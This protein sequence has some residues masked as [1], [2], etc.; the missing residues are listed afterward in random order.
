MIH[1]GKSYIQRV[2]GQSRLCADITIGNHRNTLWFSVDNSQEQYLCLGRADAFVMAFLAAAMRGDHELVCEDPMS[3]RLH[4]QLNCDLIPA[5]SSAIDRYHPIHITAPLTAEPYPNAGA[6]GTAFSGGVDSLYTI[7]TH[8][9]DCGYPISHIVVYNSS[10]FDQFGDKRQKMFLANCRQVVRF[11]GTYGLQAVIVDTNFYNV[12]GIESRS[13]VF[14]FRNVAC[15]LAL[16]GLLSCYLLSSAFSLSTF[17]LNCDRLDEQHTCARYDWLIVISSFT[18]SLS[19]Y[20]SG[21][22]IK[23]WQKIQKLAD[24]QPSWQWLHPCWFNAADKTNC[25]CCGKCICDLVTLYAL[26]TDTLNRYSKVFNIPDF[27]HHLPERVAYVILNA[28]SNIRAKEAYHLLKNSGVFIP[29]A[30]YVY[31]RQFRRAMEQREGGG[32]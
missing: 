1:I 17:S 27:L 2:D 16:Q 4:Y 19:F 23:R 31:E 18:E 9:A 8:G 5:L 22:E 12:L 20:L 28:N 10:H 29:P 3:E 14:T 21:G 30:A 11:A 32:Q 26:G 6:V 25:G 24:W 15:T 13:S 7:M